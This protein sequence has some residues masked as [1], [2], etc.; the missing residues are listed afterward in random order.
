MN[1]HGELSAVNR[2]LTRTK[3]KEEFWK[4]LSLLVDERHLYI[5]RGALDIPVCDVI[6]LFLMLIPCIFGLFFLS[7]T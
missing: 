6:L 2:G 5:T 1:Q 4:C 3:M 7:M